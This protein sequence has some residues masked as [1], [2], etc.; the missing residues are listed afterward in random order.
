MTS[1][2]A[3]VQQKVRENAQELQD[4]LKDLYE[5]EEEIK[6]KDKTLSE[7]A[8]PKPKDLPPIRES[9]STTFGAT[10]VKPTI[11]PVDKKDE[12]TKEQKAIKAKDKG[13]ELFNKGEYRKAVLEYT[14]S[15][16][17]DPK[18][19]C[20]PLANRAMA[21]LKLNE[22][23]KAEDDCTSSIELDN[24][25][26][27]AYARRGSARIGL[28]KHAEAKED[29]EFVLKLEPNNKAALDELSKLAKLLEASETKAKPAKN[30]AP[31]SPRKEAT[32]KQPTT[33]TPIIEPT[34]FPPT[35]AM[36]AKVAE[37]EPTQAPIQI[38]KPTVTPSAPKVKASTPARRV[39][40]IKVEVPKEAPKTSYEFEAFWNS[41]KSDPD[42]LYQYLKLVQ[43]SQYPSLFQNALNSDILTGIIGILHSKFIEHKDWNGIYNL[44][45]VNRFNMN[46]MFLDP[47]E[48]DQVEQLLS[49][50]KEA[51]LFDTNHIDD[52]AKLYLEP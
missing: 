27:K 24:K 40:N 42:T 10:T 34:P 30:E 22:F 44:S 26:I 14:H 7:Q 45:Q 19:A 49:R 4:Y 8:K 50:L 21:Y 29:F 41:A 23:Q 12:E 9:F 18:N 39:F 51:N 1:K 35:S 5:W 16:E 6:K 11:I 37:P 46:I 48:R 31:V 17:L 20:I 13:N 25:Y 15:L 52:L 28:K 2:G 47:D 36:A 3:N 43:P 33:P 32:T 38:P